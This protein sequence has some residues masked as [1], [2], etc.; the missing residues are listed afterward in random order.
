MVEPNPDPGNQ[1]QPA[2]QPAGTPQGTPKPGEKLILGKY[3]TMEE[4]ETAVKEL[5]RT[6]TESSTR[7]KRAEELLQTFAETGIPGSA[8]APAQPQVQTPG[9]QAVQGAIDYSGIVSNP[10]EV[11]NKIKN[12]AVQ[13]AVNKAVNQVSQMYQRQQ[14]AQGIRESFYSKHPELKGHE[15]IVHFYAN[16]VDR[17]SAALPL[18]TK[19]DKIAD[20]T[21]DYISKIKGT[22]GNPPQPN[23]TPAEPGS[24]TPPAAPG[25]D[26]P[27]KVQAEDQGVFTEAF[28]ERAGELA[29]KRLPLGAKKT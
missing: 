25:S 17:D 24:Q 4:A 14:E 26:T 19:F 3:K 16:Q 12:D 7:A 1:P 21:A 29:S 13:E 10:N 6:A 15:A 27:P 2:P 20:L 8:P 23:V 11:A 5:E 9:Q 18:E 22:S 28:N